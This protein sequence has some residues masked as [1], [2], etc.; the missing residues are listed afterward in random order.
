MKCRIL[1]FGIICL[2]VFL[3]NAYA[4]VLGGS[5]LSL[6]GYPEHECYKPHKPYEFIDELDFQRYKTD[7]EIYLDCIREY[8]ENAENDIERIREA[9]QDA[10]DEANSL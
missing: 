9:A 6:L 2:F 1:A 3:P 5:N 4:L 7:V 8:V 10:I